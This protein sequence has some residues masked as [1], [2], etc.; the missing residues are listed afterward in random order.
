M[1]VNI[2]IPA[3]LYEVLKQHLFKGRKEQGAFLFASETS[4]TSWVNLVAEDIYLIPSEGWDVQESTYLELSEEEKVKVM[5]M[6]RKR[7]CHL[8]ECHSHRSLYAAACFSPSDIYGLEEF[9]GY[10]RW[11]L[12]GKKYGALVWTKSS[13]CGQVWG[14]TNPSPIPVK[15]VRI[16]KKDGTYQPIKPS[17]PEMPGR[18]FSWS[19]FLKRENK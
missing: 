17:I 2:I 7:N 15:E 14:G 19:K 6:A 16:M 8:I 3:R 18:I 5:L 4:G 10:V 9:V 1:D 12:P 11:K 13:V